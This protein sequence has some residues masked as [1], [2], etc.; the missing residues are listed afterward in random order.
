MS[1]SELD[2]EPVT[3]GI[4]LRSSARYHTGLAV[5]DTGRR[6]HDLRVIRHDKEIKEVVT[7]LRS[8]IVAINAPLT[9][10]EGR[11]CVSKS[12]VCAS[13]GIMRVVDRACAAAGD[14][15]FP[16]LLASMINLT[17]RGIALAEYFY[18]RG[19]VVIE[20]YPSMALGIPG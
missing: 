3:L 9:L 20:G 10:P 11:C 13:A 4:D 17:L 1:V 19:T 6:L 15:P 14:R 8:A 18:E 16:A 2:R 5:L 12:C 7:F